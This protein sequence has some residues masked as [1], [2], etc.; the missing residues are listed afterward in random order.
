MLCWLHLVFSS[1]GKHFSLFRNNKQSLTHSSQLLAYDFYT[2]CQKSHGLFFPVFSLNSHKLGAGITER[3]WEKM[4]GPDVSWANSRANDD[5][6]AIAKH[7]DSHHKVSH[8]KPVSQP[9]DGPLVVVVAIEESRILDVTLRDRKA[10]L[11]VC[12]LCASSFC[13]SV[14]S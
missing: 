5:H 14:N 6:Q 9:P 4:E 12:V 2:V 13:T 3:L 11:S 1:S 10:I 8:G 7:A